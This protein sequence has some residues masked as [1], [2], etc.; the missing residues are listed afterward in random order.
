MTQV[1]FMTG[2][3]QV[4]IQQVLSWS[5]SGHM[6]GIVMYSDDRVDISSSA[7][8]APHEKRQQDDSTFWVPQQAVYT[9]EVVFS[10]F[11]TGRFDV[12]RN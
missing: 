1:M 10:R 11:R 2:A 9:L 7:H 8:R 4:V 6:T 3:M 5:P 12:R